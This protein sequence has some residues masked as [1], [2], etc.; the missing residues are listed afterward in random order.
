MHWKNDNPLLH[1]KF[2]TES[3]ILN[4]KQTASWGWLKCTLPNEVVIL[5]TFPLGL[6][7][8]ISDMA[9]LLSCFRIKNIVMIGK[10]KDVKLLLH[11]HV[12][13]H[14]GNLFFWA[15]EQAGSLR[16]FIFV[17]ETQLS[18]LLKPTNSSTWATYPLYFGKATTLSSNSF[19]QA[20]LL[21]TRQ[22]EKKTTKLSF[23]F[24][25]CKKTIG[26]ISGIFMA[27]LFISQR[28]TTEHYQWWFLWGSSLSMVTCM[29][30]CGG[31]YIL[32]KGHYVMLTIWAGNKQLHFFLSH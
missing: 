29:K 11:K 14:V 7:A 12:I 31:L 15:E 22:V 26:F 32:W 21:N 24:L 4:A 10:P 6:L 23:I 9:K 8:C 1:L 5:L 16:C 27:C 3:C 13:L 2:I 25:L 17:Q 28:L 20:G 30:S 19:L 18:L